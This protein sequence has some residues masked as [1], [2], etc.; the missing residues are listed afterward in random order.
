M[1][2]QVLDRDFMLRQSKDF[3]PRLDQEIQ[4]L[5]ADDAGR[6]VRPPRPG[7]QCRVA[8]G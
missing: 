1:I 7:C 6:T 8:A 4:L 3:Q 5:L 2:E